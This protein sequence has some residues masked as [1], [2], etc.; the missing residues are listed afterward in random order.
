MKIIT[1]K[2]AFIMLVAVMT[3]NFSYSQRIRKDHREMAPSEKQAYI[4]A[5]VAIEDQVRDMGYHHAL[6]SG[7]EIHT[8]QD[9]RRG[10]QTNGTQFLPWHRVFQLEFEQKL[11][12]A[13][14][15][16]AQ[17][18]TVPYWDWRVENT[19]SNITWDDND[20]LSLSNL[21]GYNISRN[22]GGTLGSSAD[23]DS[24]MPL[25]SFL[26]STWEA[27]TVTNTN[28]SKRLEYWHDLGHGFVGGTMNQ[29]ASP[30]DP[31]FYLH[32]GF[33]DKLWQGWEEKEA[34]NKSSFSFTSLIHYPSINP[35]N[36]ID[37]RRT[38]YQDS[39]NSI[40]ET[41]VWYAY[42]NKVLLDGLGAN[43]TIN[44]SIPKNYCYTSWNG[45]ALIGELYAGDVARNANDEVIPDNKGGFVIE[46]S[47]NVSFNAAK[48][49]SLKPGF[50]AKAN[51]RFS[52]KT[53]SAP[54][55]FTST[56]AV[57]RRGNGNANQINTNNT[58]STSEAFISPNP[59]EHKLNLSFILN[60]S[61]EV[62]I[63]LINTQGTIMRELQQKEKFPQGIHRLSWDV[64][65]IPAG[66]YLLI[67]NQGNKVKTLKVAK[68]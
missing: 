54:C 64:T 36:I 42:N 30:R 49:V 33:I 9:P 40:F 3:A 7:T 56:S 39:N 57:A 23:I 11:R 67:I 45:N 66:L 65:S 6:H 5:L 46:A 18:L 50:T 48:K 20:F 29:Q 60:E 44:T 31:V 8:T 38:Q 43:F 26:P 35:N 51:C 53:V 63:S 59:V 58:E 34:S 61:C 15:P 21:T 28:F 47:A 19:I 2:A 14:T 10:T 17:H 52:A 68:I 37:S 16:G 13:P 12:A 55:G 32:H 62:K 27:K 1:T 25:T 24:M 22:L 41:D 4:D